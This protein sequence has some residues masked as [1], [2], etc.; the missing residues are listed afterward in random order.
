MDTTKSKMYSESGPSYSTISDFVI[1][2]AG[3]GGLTLAWGLSKHGYS[4]TLIDRESSIGGL[5]KVKRYGPDKLFTEHGPRVYGTNYLS[6]KVV[7]ESLGVDW[8]KSFTPYAFFFNNIS[9]NVLSELTFHE[10]IAYVK[11]FISFLIN[12]KWSEKITVGQFMDANNFTAKGRDFIER[13]LNLTDGAGSDRY[14]LWEFFQLTNQNFAYTI[15]QP[16]VPNDVGWLKDWEKGLLQ[17]NVDILLNTN[18]DRINLL[19]NSRK[20]SSIGVTGGG[21]SYN[22]YGKQFIFALPLWNLVEIL[23][24]SGPIVQSAYG[25]FEKLIEY[26]KMS[27]YMTYIPVTL[28]W[29]TKINLPKQWGYPRGNWQVGV[30]VLSDY[31]NLDNPRSKTLIST[32]ISN[33]KKP[34]NITGKTADESTPDEIIA[35]V[36]REVSKM[37]PGLPPPTTAIVS[38]EMSRVATQPSGNSVSEFTKTTTKNGDK[39]WETINKAFVLT[40]AGFLDTVAQKDP[41]SNSVAKSQIINNMYVTGQYIGKSTSAFTS[42]EGAVTNALSLLHQL[43]PATKREFPI[44]EPLTL[45]KIIVRVALILAILYL[46]W[47][48]MH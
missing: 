31:M 25:P 13:I 28:H 47:R 37:Y 3:P 21:H 32:I 15:L 41:N 29:D 18:V 6:T 24:S 16:V 35:E 9:S 39:Q 26:T 22:V 46:L 40:P 11:G 44:I 43:V 20:I 34:S 5:H 38:P 12:P 19:P 7:L 33:K 2:G 36:F 14:T 30:V 4:V 1:V 17:N 10:I 45:R 8:G 23:K 42:M 27:E 48:A